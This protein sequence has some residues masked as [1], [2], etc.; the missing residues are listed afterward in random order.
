MVI[1][2]V[3]IYFWMWG[4]RARCCLPHPLCQCLLTCRVL[5]LSCDT[6]TKNLTWG[7][8]AP[9]VSL[10]SLHL[11][12]EPLQKLLLKY[13]KTSWESPWHLAKTGNSCAGR[14]KAFTG[15][16]ASWLGLHSSMPVTQAIFWPRL[17]VRSLSGRQSHLPWLACHKPGTDWTRLEVSQHEV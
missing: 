3:M 14:L 2:I 6:W 1:I 10:R 9:P 16:R 7:Q 15:S 8:T 4:Q 13:L 12:S 11:L 17:N 5:S